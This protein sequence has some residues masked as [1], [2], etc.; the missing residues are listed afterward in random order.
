MTKVISLRKRKLYKPHIPKKA[1]NRSRISNS[2]IAKVI[3]LLVII[4]SVLFGCLFYKSYENDYITGVCKDFI[5][6]LQHNSLI[7][8]FKFAFRF[9][10]IFFI[11][12]FFFGTSF[13]GLPLTVIPI[14][15]KGAF[16]G[17]LSSYVYCEYGLKGILFLL[18]LIYPMVIITTTSQIYS[19]NESVCMSRK[20]MNVLTNK[21]TADDISIRLYII[22]YS[23]LMGINL[24]TILINSLLLVTI[25]S[26]FNLQ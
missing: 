7:E 20:V 5:G 6:N 3:F 14:I 25:G 23:I 17:Y 24:I 11:S 16:I 21:N 4:L 22:R 8:I 18:V 2:D 13:I 15:L 26:K 9:D 10:L 19:A 1:I 12:I